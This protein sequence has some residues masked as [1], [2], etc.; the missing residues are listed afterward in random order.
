MVV[1]GAVVVVVVV[2]WSFAD[3]SRWRRWSQ[4]VTATLTLTGPK[5]GA[6]QTVL[7]TD[8]GD[9]RP[10]FGVDRLAGVVGGVGDVE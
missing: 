8:F 3:R 7:V 1:I 10:Q 4:P 5:P 9:R 6:Y 2:C